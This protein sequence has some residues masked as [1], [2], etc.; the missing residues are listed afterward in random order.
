MADML[1]GS[2]GLGGVPGTRWRNPTSGTWY[3]LVSSLRKPCADCLRHHGRV[4]PRPW[5]IPFHPHCECEQLDVAPGAEAPL[6]FGDMPGLMPR[7]SSP[8]Q[9]RV[10]GLPSWWLQRAG[11]VTWSDL[12]D[13]SGE[14]RDFDR[15]VRAK[16]LTIE[17]LVAARIPE[18]IARRAVGL[19][20][21]G[22]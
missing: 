12:F 8:G 16:H 2:N 3:Q 9:V 14:V 1:P 21:F 18:A 4:R 19:G 6:L 15:V 17:Q 5:P 20:P 22:R 11:L 10:V 7:L 13:P